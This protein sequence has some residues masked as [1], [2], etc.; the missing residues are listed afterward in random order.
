MYNFVDI[1]D[2]GEEEEKK[3]KARRLMQY[4]PAALK[5][6]A[7]VE[8]VYVNFSEFKSALDACDRIFE[9][10]RTLET[11]QGLIIT[12]PPGSSKTTLATY[13]MKSL[14]ASDL[15]EVGF[16]AITFR[17]R[18]S[19]AQGHIIS[20]LL[21]A[22]RYPF[23]NV[24]RGRV[25]AMR[26]I[27][28]EAIKQRGT[29]V[30]F[31]DQAHCLATQTKPRHSDVLEGAASDTLREMMEE[32]KVGLILLADS[33]FRGLQ[34]VDLA[35]DDRVTVRMSLSHFADDGEWQGF[36]KAFGKA[37]ECAD[38]RILSDDSV[39]AA[40]FS[41]TNGNRRSFRRLIVETVM[42]AIQNEQTIISDNHLRQ[43]FTM[44]NGHDS[45][46]KNPYGM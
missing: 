17:L 24:R 37:V 39:A 10:S 45:P 19:P 2:T 13:F 22:L 31:I 35:L 38:L 25:F 3:I 4:G 34:H 26:D 29:R 8:Q 44:V 18:T 46:R 21:H 5:S 32:T 27:A 43:A 30:V 6:G 14:P 40:T 36:L 20:G 28:F 16:G 11:P 41:A 33:S 42:I 7:L 9:L 1:E 15:F 23:A 12:G